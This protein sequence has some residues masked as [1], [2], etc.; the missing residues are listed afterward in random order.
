MNIKCDLKC[1]LRKVLEDQKT[2][3][4][5]LALWLDMKTQ[6]L[7][8]YINNRQSPNMSTALKIAGILDVSVEKLWEIQ[9]IKKKK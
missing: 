3:V 6:Q 7:Y 4:A 9:N 1:N 8:T 5:D 2:S